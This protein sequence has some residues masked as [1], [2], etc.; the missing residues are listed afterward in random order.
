[1]KTTRIHGLPGQQMVITLDKYTGS[2]TIISRC[3]GQ[4]ITVAELT[5]GQQTFYMPQGEVYVKESDGATGYFNVVPVPTGGHASGESAYQI[6]V[7]LGFEGTEL[8]WLAS[9]KG[10]TGAPGT[11]GNAG[12]TG[13]GFFPGAFVWSALPRHVNGSWQV[14][15]GWLLC[16]GGIV[17]RTDFPALFAAIGLVYTES[18]IGNDGV[19]FQLPNLMDGEG[20]FVR[21]VPYNGRGTGTKQHDAIRNIWGRV[22]GFCANRAW[23]LISEG[24]FA[25]ISSNYYGVSWDSA[26]HQTGIDFNAARVVPTANENRPLNISF[27]PLIKH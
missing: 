11:P 19:S 2:F 20:R 3:G 12:A 4:E 5:G 15:P 14:P 26:S 8:E 7:R 16:S 27:V 9:L 21:S 18:G 6:A 23:D 17:K 1:M 13:F 24:V 22:E 25:T 10:N